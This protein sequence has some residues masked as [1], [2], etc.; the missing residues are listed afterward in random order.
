MADP[1]TREQVERAIA[2]PRNI[3]YRELPPGWREWAP[4]YVLAAEAADD[5]DVEHA[6]LTRWRDELAAA[7][8]VRRVARWS[9]ADGLYRLDPPHEYQIGDGDCRAYLVSRVQAI[10]WGYE[11][12]GS[13]EP[14]FTG[15]PTPGHAFVP[16]SAEHGHERQCASPEPDGMRQCGYPEAAHEPIQPAEDSP[17]RLR[18]RREAL[19]WH[20]ARTADGL[21]LLWH[22]IERLETGRTDDDATDR[23]I[24][25]AALSA[26]EA[27]QAAL[28]KAE[29]ERP[30]P[31][32]KVGDW[33]WVA[34]PHSPYYGH[35]YQVAEIRDGW[36]RK[37]V[38]SSQCSHWVDALEPAAPP[39]PEVVD[40]P[41]PVVVVKH[42]GDTSAMWHEHDNH[43]D[44]D[45][46]G[47]NVPT[48]VALILAMADAIRAQQGGAS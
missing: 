25:A 28:A 10:A 47:V 19:G 16:G 48:P 14:V 39:A 8:P 18:E 12:E 2:K 15:R 46:E 32:F 31:R 9:E 21:P 36:H 42:C 30:A 17:E 34:Q 3:D 38:G 43:V 24:Y 7:E 27:R 37:T 5:W 22:D 1:I 29:P 40:V 45:R 13:P 33:V 23:A 6:A 44:V 11:I 41:Q 20:R 26:E 4:D 35:V